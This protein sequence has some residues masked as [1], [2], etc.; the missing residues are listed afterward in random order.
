MDTPTQ[1]LEDYFNGLMTI[2][3]SSTKSQEDQILMAGA[4][5]AVA[6][7]LYHNNLTELEYNNILQHNVRDLINLIKPTIH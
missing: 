3:D 6:K 1:I 7:M 4:M 2:V 5:M